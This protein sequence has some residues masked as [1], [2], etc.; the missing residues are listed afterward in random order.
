MVKEAPYIN[1]QPTDEY[2]KRLV[3]TS[4]MDMQTNDDDKLFL[5]VGL[6]GAGK[7][8]LSFHFLDKYHD[9]NVNI[10]H[11]VIGREKF[12][13]TIKKVKDLV[14]KGEKGLSLWFDEADSDNLEQS[15]KWNKKLFGLYMKIRYL[16]ICH[17]WCWPSLKS[18]DRR[19]VEER[20]NGVF[21]CYTKEKFNPRSYAYFPKTAILRMM[22]DDIRLNVHNLK[23]AINKYALWIGKFTD[24]NGPKKDEYLAKKAGSGSDAVDDFAAEF[25]SDE[26]E[27][28]E[29][30]ESKE[31][32]NT[33]EASRYLNLPHTTMDYRKRELIRLGIVTNPT[34]KLTRQDL[35]NIRNFAEVKSNIIK[36]YV[37]SDPL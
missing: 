36:N 18:V 2:F 30:L 24:Y 6:T 32:F 27:T 22:D 5:T 37:K 19:F 3:E 4:K 31:V 10:D 11:M 7:S 15:A 20:V 9:G 12:A 1:G 13:D 16:K 29:S 34:N 21:F 28:K 25:G 23:K 8:M 26:P 14:V 17:L 35:D 33:V